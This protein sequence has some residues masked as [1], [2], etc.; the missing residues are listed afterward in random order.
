M[1]FPGTFI[2]MA[3]VVCYLLALQWGGTTKSWSDSTVIGTLIGFGLLTILFVAVEYLQGERALL[4]GRLLKQRIFAVTCTYVFFFAGSFFSLLYYLPIYF[5]SIKNVSASNS[6]IRNL[7]LVIGASIFT[8][9]S[10]GLITAFGHFTPIMIISSVVATVG[11]G[12]LY[13]LNIN[14]SPGAWIGYQALAGIGTGF[15]LQVPIIAN[16][17]SVGPSDLS[18]ASSV[19]LFFQTIGGSFF[20][21]ASQTAFTNKLVSLIP[22]NAPGVDSHLVIAT[23]ATELRKVFTAEQIGGIL[24]AYMQ[25][26]KVTF[27]LSIALAGITV[28]IALFSP[29]KKLGKGVGTGAAV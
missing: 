16:Q 23:G 21:S 20:V 27:A 7:P 17:A 28:P 12:L 11:C 22:K 8:I 26:L 6:G 25:G 18:S 19:T 2:I 29:W 13:T 10:G 4:Q 24:E 9:I 14:S 3:A 5:Q 1:D 15:G